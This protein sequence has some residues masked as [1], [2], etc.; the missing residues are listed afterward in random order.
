MG[1]DN[2]FVILGMIRAEMPEVSDAA[3]DKLKRMLGDAAGGTRPYVPLQKKR[4]HLE[5]I[6]AAGEEATAHQ[7]SK[8]LG[9]SVVHARRLK[10]L[11]RLR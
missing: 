1:G 3:W 5:I 11:N 4:S 6:A 9:L 8:M 7:L 2:L 10:R